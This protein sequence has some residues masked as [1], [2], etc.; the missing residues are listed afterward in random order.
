M[1][2]EFIIGVVTG[3]FGLLLV[4]LLTAIIYRVGRGRGRQAVERVTRSEEPKPQGRNIEGELQAA[5]IDRMQQRLAVLEQITTD[6][7]YQTARAI[8]G[9][10]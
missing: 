1:A 9:L 6:S 3:V 5:Q 4:Q 10:R 7:G 8:D 2:E